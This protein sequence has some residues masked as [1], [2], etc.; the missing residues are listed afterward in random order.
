MTRMT[1]NKFDKLY[2]DKVVHCDTEEKAN[3]FL[4]LAESVGYKWSTGVDLVGHNYW[5]DCGKETCYHITK[6]GVLFT[7]TNH[8]NSYGYQIIE[9]Q[10]QP[11]FKVGDMVRINTNNTIYYLDGKIGVVERVDSLSPMHYDV[12]AG[13]DGRTWY[14]SENQLEK[15]EETT[16]K[17]ETIDDIIEEIEYHQKAINVLHNRLKRKAKVEN[18]MKKIKIL[19]NEVLNL[20]NRLSNDG[21]GEVFEEDHLL[22]DSVLDLIEKEMKEDV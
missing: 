15:V 21:S 6:D 20:R 18:K 8:Y 10:L 7:D 9:Y 4:A 13:I 5:E 1:K 14:L 3:E 17:E 22:L 11:K 19:Y 16:S 12:K 2:L